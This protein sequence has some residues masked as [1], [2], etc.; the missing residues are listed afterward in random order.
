MSY[1]AD[2]NDMI[3]R[4][5]SF[6]DRILKGAKPATLPLEQPTRFEFVINERTARALGLTIPPSVLMR[7]DERIP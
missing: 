6:V 2:P 4:S 1:G 3:R 5:A 7:V